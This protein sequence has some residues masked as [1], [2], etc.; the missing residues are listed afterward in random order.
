MLRYIGLA[1]I[2]LAVTSSTSAFEVPIVGNV[3]SKCSIYTD[4]PGVYGNPS[5]DKLSTLAADGGVTPVIRID[6]TAAEYYT[7][8]I[9]WPNDFSSSPTLDDAQ[10]W[11]GE[12][13]VTGTST[14]DM[15]G[16][17]AAKLEYEN[18]TE[19]SLTAA[20]STWFGITSTVEYGQG[21]SLPGGEYK[22][23]VVAECI[24]D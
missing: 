17:E 9:S 20:G 19:Y 2:G 18:H 8:K 13:T 22:A 1:A 16:Y 4:T 11:D 5:P 15:S 23:M 14:T 12:V 10:A 6:V 21:K 24:A 7:A 3:S